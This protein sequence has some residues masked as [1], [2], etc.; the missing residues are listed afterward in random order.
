MATPSVH[1]QHHELDAFRAQA[2]EATRTAV[3]GHWRMGVG[4]T[5]KEEE[6]GGGGVGWVG[7]G[8]LWMES[9]GGGKV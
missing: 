3:L 7:E 6:D 1:L 4:V 5:G 9:N 8:V 2:L